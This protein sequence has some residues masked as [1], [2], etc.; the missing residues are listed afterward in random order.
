[1]IDVKQ[2]MIKE[3]QKAEAVY[4]IMSLC[5]KMPYVEC[6]PETYDDKV[7][8]YFDE[9]DAK[10]AAKKLM[11]KK[12]PVSLF[13]LVNNAI[14]PFFVNLFPLGVNCVVVKQK[15]VGAVALQLKEMINRKPNVPL[16][17]GKGLVENPELH[18]TALYYIQEIKSNP[19]VQG[20]TEVKEMY[21]EMM[22]H[23][24]KGKYIMP[25]R[26][27]ANGIPLLKLN[28]GDAYQPIF[29]DVQEFHKFCIVHKNDKFKMAIVEGMNLPKVMAKEAVGLAL[30]PMGVNVQL[31]LKRMEQ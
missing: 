7:F 4:A 18:L 2:H 25:V 8:I 21:E 15:G 27:E 6:D 28:N 26:Q 20:S 30:N 24:T 29:T 19:E 11:E 14:L 10:N 3:L 13:K 31:K 16:P 12:V 23:F 1:M 5:T 9:E 17:E 22:N